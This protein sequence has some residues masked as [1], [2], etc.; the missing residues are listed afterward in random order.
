MSVAP[1]LPPIVH[2]PARARRG[3]IHRGAG[4][5]TLVPPLSTEPA[6]A[7]PPADTGYQPLP[8]PATSYAPLADTRAEP[9]PPIRST[10]AAL[11]LTVRGRVLLTACALLVAGVLVGLAYAGASSATVPSP[12]STPTSVVVVAGDTLWSIAVRVAPGADPRREVAHLQQLNHLR[13]EALIP[14]Q[15]LRIR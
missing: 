15:V 5:L 1:Q 8:E 4:V 11:R 14:G 10:P 13:S 6:Q 9:A 12:T 3:G 7:L 2:I